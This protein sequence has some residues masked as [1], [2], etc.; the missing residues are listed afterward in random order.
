[1][2][3]K[4]LKLAAVRLP[5]KMIKI[6]TIVHPISNET[7]IETETE[8]GIDAEVKTKNKKRTLP[9][10]PK[11][12]LKSPFK[13]KLNLK[14]PLKTK[15]T[16]SF[17]VMIVII[18]ILGIY[19][20]FT[21]SQINKK[22]AEIT[23]DILPG[24]NASYSLNKMVADFRV[25]EYRHILAKTIN[26]KKG[27]ERDITNLDTAIAMTFEKYKERVS[28][29]A[30]TRLYESAVEDWKSY[31]TKH[32]AT[33]QLSN[34]LANDQ[35]VTMM[36]AGKIEF[37]RIS[38]TLIKLVAFN[39]GQATAKAGEGA[40]FYSNSFAILL[41]T[42]FAST[43]IGIFILIV[44]L[45]GIIRPIN[46][47]KSNLD[48]LVEKGGDLTQTIDILTGDEIELLAKSFNQFIANLR[49][50]IAQVIDNSE[51]IHQIG[52]TMNE[53]SVLLSANVSDISS[54]TQELA[55][56]TEE[57]SA[58]TVEMSNVANDLEAV[59]GEIAKR[60]E[61]SAENATHISVRAEGV[62][63]QAVNSS[64]LANKVYE[65]TH[66][67][68]NIAIKNAKAV[69]NINVLAD[70]IL[71][72]T[73]QTNLLAL[74]AAIEAARAGEAGRGFAVVADEIRKLAEESKKNANQIQ[75]VTGGI[76]EAVQYLSL[77][78]NELLQF[79]DHQ[80]TPDYDQMVQIAEQYSKDALYYSDM[81]VD[82]N[83]SIEEI[84]ASV[85]NMVRSITDISRSAEESAEGTTSIAM[86][87]TD[88]LENAIA[89]ENVTKEALRLS[90]GLLQTVSKFKV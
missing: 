49:D 86:K 48:S 22:S 60:I 38:N 44:T 58:T 29:D 66:A 64:K 17:G 34:G 12:K 5:K 1:M 3:L 26:E 15:L 74:N 32:K 24:I 90:E 16:L 62:K 85:Q 65:E 41:I 77:S 69:E 43:I 10:I 63:T 18:A 56:T 87:S 57:T 45:R 59:I 79:I 27:V 28:S 53:T 25:L 13:A 89:V 78:A 82:L 39:T 14:M 11:M 54:T 37:D 31:M 47:L 72:I 68:L 73:G 71:A 75:S 70:S 7:Q 67:K 84:L 46:L 33:L 4:K 61:A 81:S 76:V 36:N 9:N 30:D 6:P 23:G 40:K 55:A 20:I 51:E 2:K 8:I 88:M 83:A 50:I 21:M 42:V 80:V 19:S 52:D 35:A